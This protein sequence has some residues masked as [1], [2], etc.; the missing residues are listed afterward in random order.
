MCTEVKPHAGTQKIDNLPV[1]GRLFIHGKNR[2]I[3]VAS[4]AANVERQLRDENDPVVQIVNLHGETI[5]IPKLGVVSFVVASQRLPRVEVQPNAF[6]GKRV[7]FTGLSSYNAA[8]VGSL[9]GPIVVDN[10]HDY[11]AVVAEDL[12][13]ALVLV[14]NPATGDIAW[15]NPAEPERSI[16]RLVKAARLI[17][18]ADALMVAENMPQD[19]PP[20]TAYD[21]E[22]VTDEPTTPDEIEPTR[23]IEGTTGE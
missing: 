6:W 9:E 2:P 19:R 20:T 18:E 11:V 13:G 3:L 7:T 15:V 1:T 8:E 21:A 10:E 17:A 16:R 5:T 22:D 12:A 4:D 23:R 14:V